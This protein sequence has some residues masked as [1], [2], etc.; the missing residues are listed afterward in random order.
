MTFWTHW[1]AEF[2]GAK[3][4]H[5]EL[6]QLPA[7]TVSWHGCNLRLRQLLGGVYGASLPADAFLR[8]AARR[9]FVELHMVG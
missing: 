5:P 6:E 3:H 4:I 8:H 9:T 2:H 7:L 1:C